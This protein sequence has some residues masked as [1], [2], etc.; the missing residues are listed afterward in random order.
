MNAPLQVDVWSD[1]VCP[2]CTIGKR[3]LEAAAREEGVALNVTWH[4]FELDPNAPASHPQPLVELI[5]T[6]Y[7][8]GREQAQQAQQQIATLAAELGVV[9]NWQQARPGNTFDAHRLAHFAAERGLGDAAQEQ[10]MR[11]YFT[12]G[13]SVADHAT[14]QAIGEAIG[15]PAAEVSQVLA[16]DRYAAEV[17]RDEQIAQQ[18][19]QVSGVPF[20]VI[21]GRL[22]I[23]G[24][25]PIELFRRA[26]RQAQ[27]IRAPL[28]P[29]G[30]QDG[31]VCDGDAC[32]LPHQPT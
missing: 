16:S 26:L 4:S 3:R 31:A 27:D 23:S 19:L 29:M 1:I 21:D 20:F 24:A 28:T 7:G 25:Q 9:F 15:L 17:R 12:E 5:A 10:L 32:T 18:Q 13:Q 2:F 6:K 22:A 30:G 8:M 11:A 14:L